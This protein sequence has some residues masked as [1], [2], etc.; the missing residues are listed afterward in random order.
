[1]LI[2]FIKL[3]FTFCFATT[4]II[5]LYSIISYGVLSF[6]LDVIYI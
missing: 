3:F 1:M 5:I 4:K 2:D 6:I